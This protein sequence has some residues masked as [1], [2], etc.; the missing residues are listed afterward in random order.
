[1]ATGRLGQIDKNRD[2]AD[3]AAASGV[4]ISICKV[5]LYRE[6]YLYPCS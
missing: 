4:A 1:M 5:D 2:D 6:P 3:R